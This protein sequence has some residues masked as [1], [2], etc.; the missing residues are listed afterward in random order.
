MSA[1]SHSCRVTSG[2]TMPTVLAVRLSG[3]I[4]LE[5]RLKYAPLPADSMRLQLAV[6]DNPTSGPLAHVQ[7][8]RELRYR[9]CM[10]VESALLHRFVSA[11]SPEWLKGISQV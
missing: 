2:A 4:V 7:T 1:A 10:I 5:V 11:P 6:F 9:E 3:E 8:L